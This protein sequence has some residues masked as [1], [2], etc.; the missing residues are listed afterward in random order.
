MDILYGKICIFFI[1]DEEIGRGVDEVDME[2]LGVDFGYI[3]DGEK[4]GLLEDEIFFV[5]GVIV[6]IKGISVYFGF[7]KGKMV[8]VMKVVIVFLDVLFIDWFIFEV[9]S[10][11]EGFVYLV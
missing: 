9:I 3:V 1:F 7:V 10:D 2:K 6:I 4:L 8:S 11:K 5:D